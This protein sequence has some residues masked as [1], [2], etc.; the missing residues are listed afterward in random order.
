ML[1]HKTGATSGISKKNPSLV[2]VALVWSSK[3]SRFVCIFLERGEEREG[4]EGERATLPKIKISNKNWREPRVCNA[5]AIDNSTSLDAS[6][7]FLLL[8]LIQKICTFLIRWKFPKIGIPLLLFITVRRE[9][10]FQIS[11]LEMPFCEKKDTREKNR[12]EKS[13]NYETKE[14]KEEEERRLCYVNTTPY[15]RSG[16]FS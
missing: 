5:Q 7:R 8:L 11:P 1:R 2:S 10:R 16:A 3:L 6:T 9:R 4:R 14:K 12:D 13:K 15:S